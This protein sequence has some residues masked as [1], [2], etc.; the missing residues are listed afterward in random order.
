MTTKV[1]LKI[2]GKK[3]DI[4]LDDD[5][6]LLKKECFD[7]A[8]SLERDNE[9]KTLLYAYIKKCIEHQKL[10]DELRQIL[11]KLDKISID[12][13]EPLPQYITLF[14]NGNL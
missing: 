8:L 13:D 10:E 6:F 4:S 2:G 5:D 1:S 14:Q 11:V 12:D 9:V 7:G 3:F